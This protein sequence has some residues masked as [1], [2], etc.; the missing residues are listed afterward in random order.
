MK[1]N[2][3]TPAL[4]FF[5]PEGKA[6]H[7]TRYYREVFKDD[8]SSEIPIPLGET[9]GGNAEMCTIHFFGQEYL[10]VSTSKEHHP[11]NDSFAIVLRCSNQE[12]IDAFWDYF[13]KE[14]K[15]SRCG[16]CQDRFGLRWQII[17]ENMGDLLRTPNANSVMMKQKKIVVS[18]YRS[19]DAA[20]G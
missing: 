18:E 1:P 10:I 6:E 20:I 16:W 4:W 12:E 14:G 11:F 7:V 5:V 9:P 8:F 19:S 15:E 17:P 13:T 3:I 2:K